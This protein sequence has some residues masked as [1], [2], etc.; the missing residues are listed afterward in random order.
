M[1]EKGVLRGHRHEVWRICFSADGRKLFSGARDGTIYCW[2]AQA[3]APRTAFEATQT[4]LSNLALAPDATQ[5]AGLRQGGVCLGNTRRSQIPRSI[6]ALGTNN[7]S[8]LFSRDGQ[9]LFVGTRAGEIQ[10]WSLRH[11]RIVKALRGPAEPVRQLRQDAL[12]RSLF[13]LY[14][15]YGLLREGPCRLQVW[16]TATGQTQA[17]WAHP[18]LPLACALSPDGLRVATGHLPGPGVVLVW[19]LVTG[20]RTSRLAFA[21]RI[22]DLAFSPDGRHLAACTL[23]GSVK[24]WDGPSLRELTTIRA[25]SFPLHGLAFSPDSRR[26]ATASDGDEAVRLWDVA[27]W[28]PLITLRRKGADIYGLAFSTQG[29]GIAAINAPAKEE[30]I[31]LWQVPSLL[32]IARREDQR[33]KTK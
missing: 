2:P 32:E 6:E 14:R 24:I 13:A 15:A 33:T 17:S 30:E 22:S 7:T 12:G 25:H 5:F 23:E 3:P 31:L 9:H 21:G 8:L 10:V 28:Q 20:L 11:E 1:A 18:R 16:S 29:K 27:T 19:D 26:L 4:D